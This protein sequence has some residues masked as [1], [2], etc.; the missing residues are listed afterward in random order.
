MWDRLVS[1]A[2]RLYDIVMRRRVDDE[3]RREFDTHV[4]LL[5]ERYVRLGMSHVEAR[6]AAHRQFGNALLV[7]E[8]IYES[9]RLLWVG[10]LG[11]DVRYALRMLHRSRSFAAVSIL[12]LAIGVGVTTALFSVGYG[13]L[14]RPLPYPESDQLVRVWESHRGAVAPSSAPWLSNLTYHAWNDTGRTIGRIAAFGAVDVTLDGDPP[15]RLSGARVSPWIFDVLR[16]SPLVGRFFHE[17]EAPDA[18]NAVVVLS[19]GVWRER[20]GRDPG[21][22]G[23]TI[24]LDQRPHTIVGIAPPGFAFPY[25]ETRVWTPFAVVQGAGPNGEP[26]IAGTQ[27]IARLADGMTAAQATFEGTAIASR[28]PRPPGT[29]VLWGDGGPVEV[30]ARTM[31]DDMTAGVRP[32]VLVFLA[33]VG[34]LLLIACANVTNLLMLRGVSREREFTL[35]AAIGAG[36][37]RMVRQLLTESL[38]M[39]SLGAT[40]GI[41]LAG[42]GI[43]VVQLLAPANFPRLDAI[44]LDLPV[45]VFACGLSLVAGMFAGLPPAI[46]AARRDLISSL[47]DG[48]AR[49]IGLRMSRFRSILVAA[50]S[51]IGV[52][53]VVAA[54]LLGRS[55]F[56]LLSVD[57]GYDSGNVLVAEISLPDGPRIDPLTQHARSAAF[58][59]ELLNRLRALPGVAAAGAGNMAPFGAI[60]VARPLTI[61]ISGR[62]AI[63]ARALSYVVTPGYAE[64]LRLRL[65]TGRFLNDAD[66]TGRT[67]SIVVNEAFVRTFLD[68]V[69]PIGFAVEGLLARGVRAEIVGVVANVRKDGLDDAPEPEVY[70]APAY[71]LRHDPS[72]ALAHEILRGINLV[73][74]THD[75]PAALAPTLREIVRELRRDAMLNYATTLQART[76]ESVRTERFAAVM[77][78]GFSALALMLAAVGLYTVL[79][80]S[81]STRQREIGVRTAL[82]ANPSTVA[83]MVVGE[84]MRVTLAGLLVGIV[85]ALFAMRVMRVMLFGIEPYD[86]VSLALAPLVLAAVA[87]MAT[88]LPAI[89]AMRTDPLISLR[90]E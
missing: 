1:F 11:H 39:A 25:P 90:S 27:A 89:H 53:L 14:I 79:S 42:F 82:G 87:L 84:G 49:T 63:T 36:R 67:Q 75:D 54:V 33:G 80:Y 58:R 44:R 61:S 6:R 34:C 86:P 46:R 13:V 48:V 85:G 9:H 43:R 16:V 65:R 68:S 38:V 8:E 64:A 32:V 47:R 30:H 51:A 72:R 71:P 12:T 4:E 35:R 40:L 29:R 41:A 18:A 2:S 60:T 55:L 76:T 45:V 31:I 59:S 78:A 52:V 88:V 62:G 19:D 15:V 28:Q 83:W 5:T 66:L 10:D 77:L 3:A 7:R 22:I 37:G 17:N 69:E 23:R 50:E 57:V 81:V 70:L 21:V 24:A 73:V 20:F 56:Q 26:R 74:R